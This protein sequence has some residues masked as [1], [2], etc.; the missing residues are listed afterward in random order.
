[1]S[2]PR[3]YLAI[4]N[5]FAS[6]RWT[7][8]LEWARIIKSMGLECV[9]A[10]TDNECDPLYLDP[11]YLEDWLRAV[12]DASDQTGVR[13]ANLYSGHG[14]YALLGLASPDRRNRGRI[15][16]EWLKVLIRIASRLEAGLGFFC[17]G[18]NQQ[19]LQNPGSFRDA[20]DALYSQLAELAI[21]ASNC[22][23]K[24][25]AIEQMYSPHLIP[26]TIRGTRR[27]L[28]E[29]WG[30]SGKPFYITIDTGHQTGQER[31]RRPSSQEV[32]NLLRAARLGNK[33]LKAK[34]L[35]PDSA[36]NLFH[37]AV[38]SPPG[39]GRLLHPANRG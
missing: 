17:H 7:Q 8:P 10:S 1:M 6:K 3:V 37:R 5:C 12:K 38:C 28:H 22:G 29:V 15:V 2:S 32:W 33:G 16:E 18:F 36:Y 34:W 31:F 23:T 21:Y 9:E 14:T 35:G 20:E 19:I 24:T 4:D 11:Q 27:L 30:R 13:I 39:S 25:T 26:W